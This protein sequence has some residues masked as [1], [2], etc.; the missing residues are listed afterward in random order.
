MSLLVVSVDDDRASRTL[1]YAVD[2]LISS[3]F[4][5]LGERLAIGQSRLDRKSR[6]LEQKFQHTPEPLLASWRVA[7]H[8]TN[9]TDPGD[10]VL[11]SDFMGLGGVFALEQAAADPAQRRQLWTVAADSA[12][13]ELRFLAKT[14][15]GLP[16]PLDSQ[17]DWEQAQYQWSDR[18]LATSTVALAE[19]EK[20]GV[21]AELVGRSESP[22]HVDLPGGPGRIWAPGT[23]CRRNQTGEVL[24]ALSSM[25]EVTI[26]VSEE[27]EEDRIWTGS[28]WDALRH[29][30]E[31]L[32]E[33]LERRQQPTATPD[34]I[35]LGDPF[36]PP[37]ASVASYISDGIP[38]VVPQG[39]VAS[40]IWPEA[41]TWVDPDDLT[42]VLTEGRHRGPES[43]A[44][45][46]TSRRSKAT[47]GL[48]L[49][50]ARAVSVGIPVFRD[51]R[52]LP[53]CVESVLGQVHP[54]L[55]VVLV[56]DGSR[57]DDVG[58]ALEDLTRL[59]SRLRIVRTE[60][61]GVSAA[62]N[63]ALE[64]FEGD[65]FL[66]IDSDD[67]LRPTFLSRCAAVLNSRDDVWAVA[68][69][70]EFFGDYDGI[71]AKPPFDGRV[72]RRENPIISTCALVDREV[73][74]RGIRFA[75]ELA[76]LYCEDWHFWSQI[77]AAGGRF[78]LVPEPLA[79]HRVHP[80]SGGFMRTE[81][82]YALGRSRATEP[83][84][85]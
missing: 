69:W 2:L 15:E 16:M 48:G 74:Q 31:L 59:D 13:L 29:S 65:S 27:D 62:R 70:T 44:N 63:A 57:S 4:D 5:T 82:A 32:G 17:V 7:R 76:F 80:S 26:T 58:E 9:R 38:V 64:V 8:L 55:E 66:F 71:E 19:L 60:H 77:V 28:T 53:E 20:L 47:T 10:T 40:L 56:D 14:H 39:S 81:L 61:R 25:P 68:T 51:V 50:R 73:V 12:L 24:R 30:R 6:L 72:G 75:P 84:C 18:V 3:G 35:V 23:V 11:M 79:R 37:N 46:T 21:H 42:A 78:G 45:V 36:A 83:L 67:L 52:F 1:D 33:Q 49:D 34:V 85:R 54:P 22:P 41:P 43:G